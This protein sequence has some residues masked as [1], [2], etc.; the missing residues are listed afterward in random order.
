MSI[1]IEELDIV[2]RAK[3][4]EF[5]RNLS[6]LQREAARNMSAV[7]RQG[8]RLEASL[9]QNSVKI[10][11]S[12]K[13]MAAAFG[14]YF[15]GRE[16]VGLMD[17]F[18]RLQNQLKVA[19]LEGAALKDVQD[20]LFASGQRYGASVE[21]LAG[22]F[23]RLSQGA[24]ELGANQAQLLQFSRGVA[25]ALKVQGGTAASTQGA[26]L[27]L[28]QALGG[29]VVRAEEFNSINEGARPILQAVANNID[30]FGGSVAKLR[31]EVLEGK[32][33]SQEFFQ[34]F[35][36]GSKDLEAQAGRATLTTAAALTT[37]NNALTVYFGEADKANGVSAALGSAI[38]G[39]AENLD[40][41]IPAIT[42][43]STA[44][45]IGFV[46]NAIAAR[47]AAATTATAMG[48]LGAT[49]TVAGRAIL[50]AF[51]GPVGIAISAVA[52][53]IG[54]A[55]ANADELAG[56]SARAQ[57]TLNKLKSE[58]K[59]AE[60]GT[61]I[62]ANALEIARKKM[63]ETAKQAEVLIQKLYGVQ[64]AALLAAR[65]LAAAK[66]G[67]AQSQVVRARES[68]QRSPFSR[69]IGVE[70][71][72]TRG[73]RAEDRAAQARLAAAN[74]ELKLADAALARARAEQEAAAKGGGGGGGSQSASTK[75][76]R[77]SAASGASGPSASEIQRQFESDLARIYV[78]RLQAELGLATNAD[79]R[80]R[81]AGEVMA[82]EYQQRRADV[83]AE[84]NYSDKK[85]QA[86]IAELNRLYGR[87][88]DG[89]LQATS[90]FAKGAGRD[91]DK[92]LA[93]EARGIAEAQNRVERD[94]LESAL[95]MTDGREARKRIELK[96]LDLAY[97]DEKRA[98][99]DQKNDTTISDAKRQEAQ[100]RFDKL[101]ELKA[102]DAAKIN[103]QYAGPMEGFMQSL[104]R[105]AADVNDAF[106]EV[107][108][109]GIKSVVDGLADAAVGAQNLGSVFKNV[110]K[111]I[112]ADLIRIQIQKMI[113]GALGNALGGL[114]GLFGGGGGGSLSG[115]GK[116]SVNLPKFANGGVI[117]VGGNGGVDQN[118]LSINGQPRA[119]VSASEHLAVVPATMRLKPQQGGTTVIQNFTL[120]ARHGITTPEL[121]AH[122]NQVA[123]DKATA[124]GMVGGALG[125]QRVMSR[126][127]RRIP[128]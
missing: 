127:R 94:L 70:R 18:T 64:G 23:G 39:I 53:A 15:S 8:D 79:D 122:V 36:K 11:S 50:G 27:Q 118:V 45:G 20:Q 111:Q 52:I 99:E 63:D 120:D 76:T 16:L 88:E 38:H 78:E 41:V 117:P 21:D 95:A 85:K 54:F 35:L 69:L 108:V 56:S 34:A 119:M 86:L 24:K 48:A 116:S 59:G 12:L 1:T 103:R 46:T 26:I 71:G 82:I 28:T 58:A 43:I 66:V 106:E 128:G 114:G 102:G 74:E 31:S 29:A 124:A 49:A 5:E 90:P 113:V 42:T 98:L 87:T 77:K 83:E 101:K 92:Q 72:T 96:L 37:L 89:Q 44:L 104:P 30:R 62:L 32:V 9:R 107:A 75:K 22:L 40:I 123:T 60:G 19:G 55:A 65:A 10:A 126:G 91:F 2:I 7:E 93:E 80:L 14:G 105:T 84:K 17:S 110:A 81:L 115:F 3:F 68:D 13:G 112:I 109:G 57:E 61:N 25:A 4:D 73:D 97:E 6:K 67:E 33:T 121:L 100:I 51:G 47:V 125:E